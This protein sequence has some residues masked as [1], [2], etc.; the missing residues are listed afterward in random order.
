MKSKMFLAAGAALL[1]CCTAAGCGNSPA[2]PEQAL[3]QKLNSMSEKDIEKEAEKAAEQLD[4]QENGNKESK[5]EES[6]APEITYAP[7]DEIINADFSSGLVQIGNDIFHNGGYYTVD[8]FISEFGSKY[9]MS[10]IAPDGFMQPGDNKNIEIKSLEDPNVTFWVIVE[11]G[12]VKTEDT[13]VR[14][15]DALVTSINA[16]DKV[17]C[18]WYPKGIPTNEEG[19]EYS[20]AAAFLEKNGFVGISADEALDENYMNYGMYWE[21]D[22]NDLINVD[23]RAR[24]SEKNLAG[25]YPIYDYR[26]LYNMDTAKPAWFECSTCAL[27]VYNNGDLND[28]TPI[29]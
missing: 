29:K 13:K 14:T 16:P 22:N 1:I 11:S 26:F 28:F 25:Y 18:C 9:D 19:F 20:G 2:N 7:K 21:E 3:E 6:Q 12:N 24:G 27:G 5:A 15:G 10:A 4:N 17:K 8:Q 23:F